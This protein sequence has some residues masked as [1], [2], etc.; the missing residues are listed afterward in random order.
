MGVLREL[1]YD[2]CLR[3]LDGGG[4]GRVAITEHALP[5]IVPVNFVKSGTSIVFRTE[6]GGMLAHGCDG[7]VVA[8]EI[9][10]IE[11]DGTG[12]WSVL[13]VGTAHLL[14]GSDAVRAIEAGLAS[15][16]TPDRNQFV[17]V[18]LGQVSGREVVNQSTA[19]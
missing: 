5:A 11:P 18:S 16:V 19:A 14:D 3:R 8:F 10:E 2:E 6:P 1:T 9:D 13:V 12:G 15:A 7:A 4:V 17:A